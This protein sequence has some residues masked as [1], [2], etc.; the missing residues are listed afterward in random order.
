MSLSAITAP[1]ELGQNDEIWEE[2]DLVGYHVWI[3]AFA[4]S[5]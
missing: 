3:V 5:H 2:S 4:L 1:N